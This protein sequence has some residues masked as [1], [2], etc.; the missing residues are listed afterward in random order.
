MPQVKKRYDEAVA[1]A[2]II[3]PLENLDIDVQSFDIQR[4][5]AVYPDKA[6]LHWW[7][8]SWFNNSETGEPSVEIDRQT[9]V[10]WI[11][12]LVGKD[13]MFGEYFPKQ[14]EAYRNA[15]EQTKEQL[16]R[17]LIIT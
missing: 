10:R 7:V 9:A 1:T 4:L 6:F 11:N 13:E 8:K 14:M 17:Q 12:H 15:I 5:V 16:L 2:G 3:D